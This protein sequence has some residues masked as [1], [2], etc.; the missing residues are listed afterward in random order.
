MT[1]IHKHQLISD[2]YVQLKLKEERS[3]ASVVMG[4]FAHMSVFV[5][6]QGPVF[7][8]SRQLG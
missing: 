7:T 6:R 1:F 8:S 2:Q 5:Y 3:H 4:I